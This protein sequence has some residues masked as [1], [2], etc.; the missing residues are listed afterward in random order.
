VSH[1]C[2]EQKLKVS[3]TE[4]FE[5]AD[6]RVI[7]TLKIPAQTG[8]SLGLGTTTGRSQSPMPSG[9][10]MSVYTIWLSESLSP[11]RSDDYSSKLQG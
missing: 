10:S 4:K 3:S 9:F 7:R 2:K 8:I 11:R 5:K 1:I 6:L